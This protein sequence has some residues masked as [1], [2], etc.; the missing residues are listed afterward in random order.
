MSTSV[1]IGITAVEGRM[2]HAEFLSRQI[3]A[4]IFLDEKRLGCAWNKKRAWG[5]LSCS[6]THSL[7]IDD[8]AIVVPEFREAVKIC[9]EMFPHAILSLFSDKIGYGDFVNSPYVLMPSCNIKGIAVLMP[10][11]VCRDFLQFWKE[12]LPEYKHDDG[13]L[14]I[15]ALLNNIDTFTVIPNLVDESDIKSTFASHS[16]KKSLTYNGSCDVQ[17]LRT[18]KY[19]VGSFFPVNTHLSKNDK[20]NLYIKEILR[21]R[22]IAYADSKNEVV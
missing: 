2:A 20:M 1:N 3:G 5:E 10:N 15:Y 19:S 18:R 11:D 17:R 8:D 7:V 22:R 4:R 12:S 21:T 9:A 14:R 6:G 16:A 13:A